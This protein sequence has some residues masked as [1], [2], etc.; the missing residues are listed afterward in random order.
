MLPIFLT[1]S[2]SA[3]T[4]ILR[5]QDMSYLAFTSSNDGVEHCEFLADSLVYSFSLLSLPS[6]WTRLRS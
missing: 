5:I 3:I 2:E 4:E 6:R 1:G